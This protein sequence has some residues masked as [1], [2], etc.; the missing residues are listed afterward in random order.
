MHNIKIIAGTVSLGSVR[1]ELLRGSTWTCQV[2]YCGGFCKMLPHILVPT[3]KAIDEQKK[4][5][6]LQGSQYWLTCVSPSTFRKSPLQCSWP[7]L[8]NKN[9]K[10]PANPTHKTVPAGLLPLMSPTES[11]LQGKPTTP[12]AATQ[13]QLVYRQARHT[14]LLLPDLERKFP[15][16]FLWRAAELPTLK[17]NSATTDISLKHSWQI[18]SPSEINMASVMTNAVTVTGCCIFR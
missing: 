16:A 2:M 1:A 8:T 10:S 13:S 6:L 15:K 11:S 5:H 9:L 14:E 12:Q 17:P 18:I 3:A 7:L 4:L